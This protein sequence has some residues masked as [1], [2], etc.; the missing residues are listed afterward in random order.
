MEAAAALDGVRWD[1]LSLGFAI[2]ID[3]ISS[4][5]IGATD[6]GSLKTVAITGCSRCREDIARIARGR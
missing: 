4:S 2:A 3:R 1:R 6:K 5:L